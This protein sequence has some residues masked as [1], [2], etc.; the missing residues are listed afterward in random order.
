MKL[1]AARSKWYYIGEGLGCKSDDLDEIS[2]KY[3]SDKEMCLKKMLMDRINSYE[4]QGTK[5]TRSMLCK[6]LRGESVGRDDV[7]TQI[8]AL[9]LSE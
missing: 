3:F 4:K 8:E 1:K 9:N 2:E 5:L 6:C 7:A